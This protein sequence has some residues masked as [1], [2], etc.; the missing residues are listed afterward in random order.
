MRAREEKSASSQEEEDNE[1][2][3]LDDKEETEKRFQILNLHTKN[4]LVSYRGGVFS[5]EWASSIGTE[6]FF[7]KRSASDDD[8]LYE[9]LRSFNA[10]DLIGTSSARLLGS[11]ATLIHRPKAPPGEGLFATESHQVKPLEKHFL[12]RLVEIQVNKKEIEPDTVIFP[13]E[14]NTLP[15]T[16]PGPAALPAAITTRG[17]KVATTR[18]KRRN[19]A[20]PQSALGAH[21]D[22][23]GL[24]RDDEPVADMTPSKWPNS[25]FR[26][27]EGGDSEE[28]P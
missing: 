3:M 26:E 21:A 10:W 23:L 2:E 25:I 8:P 1:L 22:R 16:Q 18:K 17:I 5:C 20:P 9:P 7:V 6:M 24:L 19:R 15:E 14:T 12:K 13:D 11:D 4:P 28:R 27:S